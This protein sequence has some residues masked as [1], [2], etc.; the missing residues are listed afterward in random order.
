MYSL[1]F[2]FVSKQQVDIAETSDYKW[3]I[4]LEGAGD[5]LDLKND[6]LS[7]DDDDDRKL[8][9]IAWAIF[10]RTKK[11][12]NKVKSDWWSCLSNIVWNVAIVEIIVIDR[13]GN[14]V[15]DDNDHFF[16]SLLLKF[17]LYWLIKCMSAKKC[18]Y[19]PI[20]FFNSMYFLFIL[21]VVQMYSTDGKDRI[22]Y[23]ALNNTI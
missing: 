8:L 1:S 9:W 16:F 11:T 7:C 3:Q 21:L 4:I 14:N 20:I 23:N 12:C 22:Q 17:S 18:N 15:R 10:W 6:Y 2:S 5:W 19:M 13:T